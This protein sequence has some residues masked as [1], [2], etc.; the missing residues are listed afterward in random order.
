M[1]V[2][3][4]ISRALFSCNTRFEIRLFAL[5]RTRFQFWGRLNHFALMFSFPFEHLPL[6]SKQRKH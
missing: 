2:F 3:R 4:K 6:Q 5:L 1:F